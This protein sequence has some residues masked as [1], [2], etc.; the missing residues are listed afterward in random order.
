MKGALVF[1]KK[2]PLKILKDIYMYKYVLQINYSIVYLG[3]W[4]MLSAV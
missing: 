4:E 1:R 3:T 2:F